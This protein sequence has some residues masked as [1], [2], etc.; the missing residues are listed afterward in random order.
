MVFNTSVRGTSMTSPAK[1]RRSKSAI[2]SGRRKPASSAKTTVG[3]F[4]FGKLSPQRHATASMTSAQS[5]I[6]FDPTLHP[7]TTRHIGR[8]SGRKCVAGYSRN[9]RRPGQKAGEDYL[10]HMR[11]D[12]E[13]PATTI[14]KTFISKMKSLRGDTDAQADLVFRMWDI[15]SGSQTREDDVIKTQIICTP[16][17]V[18]AYIKSDVV[19]R[20]LAIDINQCAYCHAR[21]DYDA[22]DGCLECGA[23]PLPT[24]HFETP[25]CKDNYHSSKKVDNAHFRVVHKHIYDRMAHFKALLHNMQG[26]GQG[27][28]CAGV[29]DKLIDIALADP[30]YPLIDH[31]WVIAQLKKLK[32]GRY[33]PQAVRL[34]RIANPFFSPPELDPTKIEQLE[35]GFVE[36][37]TRFDEFIKE[38]KEIKRKNFMSYPYIAHQLFIR[39]DLS[40]L[41]GYL[42]MI[43]SDVRLDA[44]NK[45]WRVICEKAAWAYKPV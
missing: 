3:S 31:I 13:A 35:L 24:F 5:T 1:W 28:L 12:T 6:R 33:I 7:K 26:L 19:L 2:C 29:T 32:Q 21:F 9:R 40:H 14:T 39:N 23:L 30:N 37:C 17:K 38:N 41:C 4:A 44:Q 20:E 45:L 42:N 8:G 27:K 25:F 18:P 36:V 22:T 15:L 34:A 11:K 43:K 16:E 10:H